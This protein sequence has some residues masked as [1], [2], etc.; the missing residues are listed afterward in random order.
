MHNFEIWYAIKNANKYLSFTKSK[1]DISHHA[2]DGFA[3]TELAVSVLEKRDSPATNYVALIENDKIAAI[4]DFELAFHLYDDLTN[5]YPVVVEPIVRCQRCEIAYIGGVFHWSYKFQP[6]TPE[7]VL[8]KVC[9]PTAGHGDKQDIP[10]LSKLLYESDLGL[11]QK[12]PAELTDFVRANNNAIEFEL[13]DEDY[14]LKMAKEI[15][16]DGQN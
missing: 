3:T 7:A 5:I 10:C 14:Y 13:P 4:M 11:L 16:G 9:I 8:A 1:D 12:T 15:L 6:T 2:Y